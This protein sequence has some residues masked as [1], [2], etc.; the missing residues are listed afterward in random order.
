MSNAVLDLISVRIISYEYHYDITDMDY[1]LFNCESVLFFI[2]SVFCLVSTVMRTI[3][4]HS[5][6]R[7]AIVSKLFSCC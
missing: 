6:C 5:R 2:V 7:Q 1:G 4:I 3:K